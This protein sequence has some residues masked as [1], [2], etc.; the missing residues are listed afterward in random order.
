M[1]DRPPLRTA[2]R[3]AD[4]LAGDE[5]VLPPFDWAPGRPPNPRIRAVWVVGSIVAVLVLGRLYIAPH[6]QIRLV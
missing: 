2:S 6:L 3:N 1:T 5:D 4:A